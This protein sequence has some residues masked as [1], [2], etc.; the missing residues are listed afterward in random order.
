MKKIIGT[1]VLGAFLLSGAALAD[2]NLLGYTMGA[3]TIPLG[4][5]EAYLHITN[6]QSKRRGD[7]SMQ[8][9]RA[10]YEYGITNSLTGAVYLNAYRHDYNCGIG[11]AGPID[12]PEIGGTLNKTQFSGFSVELK[13]ML[14]SPYKD[15]LGVSLYGELTYDTVDSITGEKGSGYEVET[16][17]I[18]QKPF[19]DGQLQW[20]NNIEFEAESFAPSS[21]SGTEYAIA[22]RYRTGVA[23]RFAPNWFIGAE[24]WVDA[25]LLNPIGGNWE[26][27]HWDAFV[28]PS[29]HFGGEK[30]WVTATAVSQIGGS[31]EGE[32]NKVGQHLAD[33]EK[34]EFKMKFGYN[35]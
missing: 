5:K 11:C 6:K 9:I 30:Y 15:G 29:I 32:D 33:H 19:M 24:G 26:F 31:N 13:K 35:F 27:D 20:V 2:E 14:L 12:D 3:E 25:E 8:A 1:A 7:Y 22:P 23:Y 21:Q 28:G 10:E 18:I 17:L 4:T 16:K 34:F